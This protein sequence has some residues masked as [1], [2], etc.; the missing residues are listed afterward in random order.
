MIKISPSKGG[1]SKVTFALPDTG[2]PVAVAG[3]FNGWD[4]SSHPLRKRTNGTRS[5]A[6][7]LPEGRYQYRYVYADGRW[8]SEE[9]DGDANSVVT[10]GS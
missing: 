4:Q 9:G 6:I 7:E 5:V 8:E 1:Q 10:V 2:T 3:E